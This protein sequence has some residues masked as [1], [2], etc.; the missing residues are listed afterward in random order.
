MHTRITEKEIIIKIRKAHQSIF[1]RD[2]L[3]ACFVFY[4]PKSSFEEH[5]ETLEDIILHTQSGGHRTLR[6]LKDVRMWINDQN[7]P[8][9]EDCPELFAILW[10]KHVLGITPEDEKNHIADLKRVYDRLLVEDKDASC[11][12]RTSNFDKYSSKF[13]TIIQ[14]S[15]SGGNRTLKALETIGWIYEST[16]TNECPPEFKRLWSKEGRDLEV[17][18]QKIEI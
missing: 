10:K 5:S 17:P 6:A 18:R 3:K 15:Q 2:K 9:E 14:H 16:P 11:C 7:I 4:Q 12:I 8:D 1:E 13:E